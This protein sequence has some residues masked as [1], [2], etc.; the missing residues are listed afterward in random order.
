V[1]QY[2]VEFTRTAERE[3]EEIAEWIAADS[4]EAAGR[5][6]DDLLAV[7]DRLETMPSRCPLAPENESHT[8]EIRQLIFGRYRVLF[9]IQPG[10]VVILHVRH[11]ARL[12]LRPERAIPP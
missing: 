1:A 10:R 5:W 4:L 9:T 11:G 8:E 3:I 12:P 7:V 2:L 6:L